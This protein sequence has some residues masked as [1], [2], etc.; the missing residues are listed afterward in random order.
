GV[1]AAAQDYFGKDVSDLTLSECTVLAGITQNPTKYNPVINPE[2]NAKRRQKVLDHML[3]QEYI[4]K[5]Q[6]DECLADNVYERIQ[7][8]E[9][10]SESENTTYSYFIDELTE[11]V[12]QDLQDK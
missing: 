8:V 9:K 2:N 4:T 5:E 12:I 11:Q 7:S 3:D 6:Y 1:Q 10:E